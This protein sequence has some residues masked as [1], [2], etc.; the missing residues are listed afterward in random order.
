[1]ARHDW[2][3]HDDF[4]GRVGESFEVT[5]RD[6]AALALELAETRLGP[7]L[8]GRGPEGQERQQFSLI[9]TG[10]ATPVLPQATYEL[11]HA[12][13]GRLLIFLVPLGPRE[14]RMRYEAA[15]A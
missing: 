1:V 7:D 12:E 6:S 11:D 15:F 9:F 13:L 4:S 10:P 3:T 14:G 2:L 5:V 8:G